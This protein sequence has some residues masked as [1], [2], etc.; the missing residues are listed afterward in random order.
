[1]FLWRNLPEGQ[2]TAVL[3]WLCDRRQA[4]GVKT[5]AGQ[6]TADE[7]KLNDPARGLTLPR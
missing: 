7:S 6:T 3:S 5:Q 4:P 2:F 1:M